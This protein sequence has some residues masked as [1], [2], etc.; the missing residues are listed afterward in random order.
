MTTTDGAG[1][2][3]AFGSHETTMATIATVPTMA[4]V[5]AM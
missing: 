2:P 3:D 1:V 4:A 5:R